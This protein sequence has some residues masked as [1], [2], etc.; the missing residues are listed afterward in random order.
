MDELIEWWRARLAEH[1]PVAYGAA[2]QADYSGWYAASLFEKIGV[3][4]L[5]AEYIERQHPKLALASINADRALLA[6][7]EDAAAYYRATPG[8]PAGELHGLLTAIKHR[9]A[10]YAGDAGYREEWAPEAGHA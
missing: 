9:A 3:G 7:Y 2:A 1:G 6:A 10:A 8:V 4:P 5:E